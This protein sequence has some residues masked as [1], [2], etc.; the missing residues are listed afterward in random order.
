MDD[1][2]DEAIMERISFE[3]TFD[4]LADQTQP[5]IEDE[6]ASGKGEAVANKVKDENDFED[7][8]LDY[9]IQ[10]FG[11]IQSIEKEYPKVGDT[12][13]RQVVKW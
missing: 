13:L 9:F 8:L 6:N 4:N 10:S 11:R 12:E 7:K 3:K 1:L 2:I 5:G